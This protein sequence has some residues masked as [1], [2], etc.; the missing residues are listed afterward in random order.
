MVLA[1]T[2][3]RTKDRLASWLLSADLVPDPLVGVE[4]EGAMMAWEPQRT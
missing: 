2:G 4:V 1:R 3:Q